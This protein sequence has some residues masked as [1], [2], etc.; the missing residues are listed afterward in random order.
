LCEK[1]KYR[2]K[3]NRINNYYLEVAGTRQSRQEVGFSNPKCY[4]S[5]CG[6]N[7]GLDSGQ[8]YESLVAVCLGESALDNVWTFAKGR[9]TAS[10]TTSGR[11]IAKHTEIRK[12][13][14]LNG[15]EVGLFPD[16]SWSGQE[17]SDNE[18]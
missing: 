11:Y 18:T 3:N 2:T 6:D 14:V 9:E 13:A 17:G 7:A 16:F 15:F 4:Q 12:D 10:V 5:A 1:G 8:A